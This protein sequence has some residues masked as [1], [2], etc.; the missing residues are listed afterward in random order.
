MEYRNIA[1]LFITLILSGQLAAQE[2]S[3]KANAFLNTL[4]PELKSQTLFPLDDEERFNVN[5]VPIVRRGPTF[6]DF[7]EPQKLAAL[8]LLRSSL[9]RE[10]YRKTIEI[11]ELEKILI[12]IENNRNKMPD[13]SPMRDPLNYH[14]CIF[15]NPSPSHFWGWR[16]E[17]HHISLNFT[18][19]EGKIVSSTP[20][21][22]GSNPAVVKIEE[23]KGKEVLKL[24]T[25]LAFALVNS[26][27]GDQLKV[28]RF[29]EEAPR[30]II[31][32]NRQKA[33]NLD[34][35]GISYASL[36][37]AQKKILMDLLYVYI[38]NYENTF[39]DSF[40]DKIRN[41]GI[42]NLYFA[43]AGSLVPGIGH[44]YRI[45][46]PALLIEYDNTQNNANHIHSVV[47]D[48]SND[49]G[50]DILKEHYKNDH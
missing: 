42:D 27:T 30:E 44:Y 11:M 47:R 14:F 46:S 13:G 21:F 25:D 48:L 23:Q 4:T 24:E 29:S 26:L 18:S 36:T 38:D 43:W 20:S 50:E 33:E 7:E 9:S 41:A 19:A 1:V 3:R 17:G 34:P 8:E 2:L 32:G 37:T 45:Q 40:K 31:T 16:F 28:A 49:F 22:F 15:G 12:L 5:F 35:K 10:G 39:S 6:H